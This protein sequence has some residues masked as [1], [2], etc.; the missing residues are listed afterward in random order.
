MESCPSDAL[1]SNETNTLLTTSTG[2]LI[3]LESIA[4]VH[5]GCIEGAN[6]VVAEPRE[7]GHCLLIHCHGFRPEG[8]PP[9]AEMDDLFWLRLVQQGWTVA[10]TSYRRS[11]LIVG[12]AIRDVFNLHNWVCKEVG[13]PAFR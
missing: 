12:D 4:T 1:V 6:F 8:T 9:F 13:I 5:R 11:G 3:D 2:A 7:K 10:V